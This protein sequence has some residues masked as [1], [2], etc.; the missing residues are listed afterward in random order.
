MPF[1]ALLACIFPLGLALPE[2]LAF[3]LRIKRLNSCFNLRQTSASMKD[4]L[5]HEWQ[6]R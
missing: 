4:A 2:L 1:P 5:M 6:S 3:V